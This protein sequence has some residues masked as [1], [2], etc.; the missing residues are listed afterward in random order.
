MLELKPP[1][2]DFP[3][4]TSKPPTL[5]MNTDSVEHLKFPIGRLAFQASY[6]SEELAKLIA[7]LEVAPGQYRQLVE[8]RSA[9]ELA[10]TYREGSWTIQQLVHHVADMQMT[11]FFRMKKA[12]TEPDYDTLTMVDMGAWVATPDALTAPIEDSLL[13][14]EGVHRRYAYLTRSLTEAQLARNCYH[15]V[16]QIWINQAQAIA[17]SAWHVQHHLAHI[18]LALGLL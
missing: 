11:H 14:F 15:P 4:N 7:I 1:A 3:G 17:M 5:P 2:F 18:K 10:K 9:E 6:T 12:I 16:R 8:N 13:M